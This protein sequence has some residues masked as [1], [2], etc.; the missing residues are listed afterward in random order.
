M[1]AFFVEH[2]IT[3]KESTA[4]AMAASIKRKA[5]KGQAMDF[6]GIRAW[7]TKDDLPH[8]VRWATDQL[9]NF[10]VLG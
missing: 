6:D 4:Q 2:V 7:Q 5:E 10:Q 9:G 8:Y 3:F 1:V